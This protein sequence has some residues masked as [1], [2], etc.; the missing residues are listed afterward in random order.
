MPPRALSRTQASTRPL[1]SEHLAARPPGEPAGKAARELYHSPNGDRWLLIRDGAWVRVR[2]VAN[3]ASGGQVTEIDIA[4]FL[5][6]GGNGPE[7]QELLRLIG[8]LAS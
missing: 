3:A 7:K 2:H 6:Q 4:S 1:S 8:E 5:R